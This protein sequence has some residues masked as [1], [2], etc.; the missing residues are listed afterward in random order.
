MPAFETTIKPRFY[1]TDGLG[2]ISNTV[3]PAWFEIGRTEFLQSLAG[4]PG[5]RRR[6]WLTASIQIDYVAETFY[7]S[8]VS[9][10]V[11]DVKVGNT[12]LT[13]FGE[14]WQDGKLTARGSSVLVHMAGEGGGKAPVPDDIREA[15]AAQFA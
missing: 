1:E 6:V 15:I 9:V 11:T 8:D 3:I 5:A 7:G 12:S 2:H 13:L 14:L 4:G 10:R